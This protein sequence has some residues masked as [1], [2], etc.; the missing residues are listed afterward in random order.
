MHR[1]SKVLVMLLPNNV[2]YKIASFAAQNINVIKLNYLFKQ[3]P[4]SRKKKVNLKC[5]FLWRAHS[6]EQT[7]LKRLSPSLTQLS[8]LTP[9]RQYYLVQGQRVLTQTRSESVLPYLLRKDV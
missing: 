2:T 5:Y 9:S 6:P 1:I 4:Y 3:I 8:Q 7:P